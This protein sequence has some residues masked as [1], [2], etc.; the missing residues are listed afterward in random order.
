MRRCRQ[1]REKENGDSRGRSGEKGTRVNN[2]E[3]INRT[4]M[5]AAAAAKALAGF[6]TTQSLLCNGHYSSLFIT[7]KVNTK[8]RDFRRETARRALRAV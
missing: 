3:E 7:T 4:G 8:T 1:E 6:L 2:Y 5:L